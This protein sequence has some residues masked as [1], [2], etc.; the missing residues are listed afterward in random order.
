MSVYPN[1]VWPADAAV[2]A[3]D[4]TTDAA[5]GLPYVAKG[6]GPTSVP[7][8]EVQYNRRQQRVNRILAAA[9]QGMVVDEGGLKIGVYPIEFTLGGVRRSYGGG[10]GVAIPDNSSRVVYVDTSV[11]LQVASDWPADVGTYL[12]LA[13]V[14][15]SAGQV[16]ITDRRNR[17]GYH[18]PSQRDRRV[19]QAYK[20]S[21]S[22]G[23]AA[24][25]VFEFAIGETLTIDEVQVFCTAVTATA[26][27]DVRESGFSVLSAPVTP[28]AGTA[29]SGTIADAALAAGNHLTVHV[30]T[31]GSGAVSDLAVVIVIKS[32]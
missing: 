11:V 18:V 9:R 5:T 1:E 19:L 14:V 10:T 7:T 15:A 6:T 8:L 26:S 28:S 25:K 31:D 17:A 27:V 30:T 4:G 12:P 23:Q 29:V 16:T 3:L 13:T 32:L 22:S 24:A 21:V 20:A 2:E